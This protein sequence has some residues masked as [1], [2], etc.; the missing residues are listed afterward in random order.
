M[1]ILV[2]PDESRHTVHKDLLCQ[3]SPYFSAAANDCWKE[4]QEGRVPLP[5]DDPSTFALYVQW[6]YR[7]RTFSSQDMTDTGGKREE[8]DLLVEAFVA[9]EEGRTP[10]GVLALSRSEPTGVVYS[11]KPFGRHAPR[12]GIQARLKIVRRQ[13]S[14]DWRLWDV[15]S[16]KGWK[17]ASRPR[18]VLV[19]L[20]RKHESLDMTSVAQIQITQFS[21]MHVAPA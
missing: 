1:T 7:D 4:G 10:P 6:L 9:Q 17:T 2:G 16:K 12:D 18:H 3:K 21:W 13:C 20:A 14:P 19:V 15:R 5:A 8:I 11:C